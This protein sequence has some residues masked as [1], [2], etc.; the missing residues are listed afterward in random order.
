MGEF[1]RYNKLH[2]RATSSH[3]FVDS[4]QSKTFSAAQARNS[5]VAEKSRDFDTLYYLEMV[6]LIK[7]NRTLKISRN[8]I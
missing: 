6:F 7:S 5:E 2:A 4:F 1:Q 8:K 3:A